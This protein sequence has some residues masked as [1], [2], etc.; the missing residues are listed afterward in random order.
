MIPEEGLSG[1]PHQVQRLCSEIQL[2]DLC[3]LKLCNHKDGGF[4]TK[5]ELL[6]R[7]ERIADEDECSKEQNIYDESYDMDEYNDMTRVDEDGF[8][9]SFPEEDDRG[10]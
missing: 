7:F 6:I 5:S 2:F 3:N 4:C 9:A 8:D 10:D 1:F